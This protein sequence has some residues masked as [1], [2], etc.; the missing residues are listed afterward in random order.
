[1]IHEIDTKWVLFSHEGRILGR[2]E[3]KWQAK[4]QE[5]A[6]NLSKAR[7]SGHRIPRRPKKTSKT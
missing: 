4:A 2:H 6:I 7:A 5:T 1:M 3:H